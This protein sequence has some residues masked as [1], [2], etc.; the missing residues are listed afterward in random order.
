LGGEGGPDWEKTKETVANRRRKGRR[1][2][3]GKPALAQNNLLLTSSI[4][5]VQG[6]R[7]PASQEGKSRGGSH[8]WVRA[9]MARNKEQPLEEETT[10][11]ATVFLGSGHQRTKPPVRTTRF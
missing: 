5:C 10:T 4:C 2:T 9:K 6:V 11:S 3:L 7:N 8:F 1:K